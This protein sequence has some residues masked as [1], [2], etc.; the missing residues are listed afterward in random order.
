[1]T[2]DRLFG[3]PSSGNTY[4]VRLLLSHL[5]REIPF[6]P[7]ED[8]SQA[9]ADAKSAGHLPFGKVPV[10]TFTD[11]PPLPESN[12]IL[13]ALAQGTPWWP[14]DPAA[15]ARVLAWM[16]FDRNRHEPVIAVRLALR[17]YPSRAPRATPDRMAALLE[18]GAG[19]LTLM[20]THLAGTDFLAGPTPT[21][22]DIALFAYT[23]RAPEAGFDLAPLPHLQA[24]LT[25]MSALPGHLPPPH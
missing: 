4:K 7:C 20:D 25:R 3:M 6:I 12:A 21:I 19:I 1:M 15:Q 14:A 8:A 22:A 9:L 13:H 18:T 17:I 24:W 5:G 11:A 2:P 16:F 10:L 23:V